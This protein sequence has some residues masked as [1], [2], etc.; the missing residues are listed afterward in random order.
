MY[1]DNDLIRSRFS[2]RKRPF[3]VAPLRANHERAE[4]GSRPRQRRECSR[5]LDPREHARILTGAERSESDS[6]ARDDVF[7][8]ALGVTEH[9]P[10]VPAHAA[11]HVRDRVRA[12]V[13]DHGRVLIA[14]DAHLSPHD[15]L[16]S[17]PQAPSSESAPLGRSEPRRERP[18]RARGRLRAPQPGSFTSRFRIY[19][20]RNR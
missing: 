11:R 17:T 15:S 16:N 10:S 5:S 13:R 2:S 20:D 6:S 3:P 12:H 1:V 14:E 8:R 4:R 7:C 9:N 18:R 19:A